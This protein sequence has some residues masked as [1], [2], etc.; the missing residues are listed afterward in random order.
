MTRIEDFT[1]SQQNRVNHHITS[2]NLTL[3]YNKESLRLEALGDFAWNVAKRELNNMADISAFD[4]SYG[5]SGQYTFLWKI[6]LATDLKM[7]SRRGYE[8]HSMNTNELVW[9]VS[10]SRPFL[11][12]RLVVKMDGFDI[13]GQLSSTRY[14]VNGQGRTETW[15]LCMPQYVMLRLAYKFNKNPKNKKT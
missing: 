12:G 3:S 7:Y 2:Q 10:I 9:N 6:Q 11:K 13:L 5:L 14:V 15:Q 1:D 8:E 4:F